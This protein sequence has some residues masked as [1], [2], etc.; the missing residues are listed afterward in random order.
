MKK[1]F[2]VFLLLASIFVPQSL[3][4]QKVGVSTNFAAW[5]TYL[6]PNLGLEV[7]LCKKLTLELD[8]IYNPFSFANDTKTHL[9]ALQPELRYYT[10]YRFTGHF[11]G[12]EGHYAMYD[13]GVSKYR[14]KGD[15]FGGGFS[16]GYAWMFA[17]RW[18]LEGVI[19]LGFT[20]MRYD[21]KY[22]RHDP[23]ICYGPGSEN[24]IGLSRLGIK[25]TY[26]IF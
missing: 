9:W 7:G 5:G 10:R 2:L 4:A 20:H 16:Y 15:L 11:F 1:K 24:I 13:W 19:G 26:L 8:G 21:Q 6:S 12:L 22:D 3:K 23:Y 17:E 14:Y 25:L 18:N